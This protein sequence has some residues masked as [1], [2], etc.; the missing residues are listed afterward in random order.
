MADIVFDDAGTLVAVVID[1][2]VE[3]R[4][5]MAAIA[6]DQEVERGVAVTDH[7]R[8]E[9]RLLT[10]QAVISDTPIRPTEAL[11]G[12]LQTYELELPGLGYH[13]KPARQTG[14]SSWA[15][16]ELGERAADPIRVQLY[17]PDQAEPTRVVDTWRALLDARDRALRATIT[18][19][20]ETYESMV[21]IEANTTRTAQDGTWI[22]CELTFKQIRTVASE[23]VDDPVPARARDRRQQNRGSQSTEEAPPQMTSLLQRGLDLL[24]LGG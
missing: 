12:G 1:A 14:P 21:L 13:A 5:R 24:G 8:P 16:A 4:H 23:L 10:L 19:R 6:T 20:L 9:P 22:K 18:T 2:T 7:V 15:A 11:G 3:E 17:T